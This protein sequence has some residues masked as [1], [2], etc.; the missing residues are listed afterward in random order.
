MSKGEIPALLREAADEI[1]SAVRHEYGW[2]D[3][4][5]ARQRKYERDMDLVT[6]LRAAA[7]REVGEDD[8]EDTDAEITAMA[9][10]A[11][12]RAKLRAVAAAEPEADG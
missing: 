11:Y 1:E 2:P 4:H 9:D 6:R 5:P 10:A 8:Q 7:E 12:E 3:V